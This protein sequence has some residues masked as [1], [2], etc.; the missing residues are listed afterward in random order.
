[1]ALLISIVVIIL[2]MA[3]WGIERTRIKALMYFI[4]DRGYTPPTEQEMMEC[5]KI[6]TQK[7][8]EKWIKA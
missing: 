2:F 5:I 6:V 8:V 1:M 7:T 4:V 3:K